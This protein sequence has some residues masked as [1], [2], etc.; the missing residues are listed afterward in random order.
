MGIVNDEFGRDLVL[1]HEALEGVDQ[2]GLDHHAE[3]LVVLV[4]A[5]PHVDVVFLQAHEDLKL[6]GI[7]QRD[8]VDLVAIVG[9]RGGQGDRHHTG[10]EHKQET[11]IGEWPRRLM[12]PLSGRQPF[13]QSPAKSY[14]LN[15]WLTTDMDGN[16]G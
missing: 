15:Q 4:G 16:Y 1:S 9:L 2:V 7:L 3:G 10:Q 6:L 14:Q 8:G 11:H 5:V 12:P 13:I